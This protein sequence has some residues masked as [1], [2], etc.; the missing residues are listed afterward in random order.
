MSWLKMLWVFAP[1]A[2]V[3]ICAALALVALFYA[4]KAAVSILR[5]WY[6]GRLYRPDSD[7]RGPKE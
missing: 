6:N 4:G 2:A 1:F 5:D 3:G 7:K